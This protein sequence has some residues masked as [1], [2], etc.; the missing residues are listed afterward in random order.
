ME[1]EDPKNTSRNTPPKEQTFHVV[2]ELKSDFLE[3]GAQKWKLSGVYDKSSGN[4]LQNVTISPEEHDT[5]KRKEIRTNFSEKIPPKE[6][7][8]EKTDT[9]DASE[10]PKKRFIAKTPLST[11][12]DEKE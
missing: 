12:K 4:T 9:K 7:K 3:N 10:N 6:E 2:I 8:N 5:P 1:D 11:K